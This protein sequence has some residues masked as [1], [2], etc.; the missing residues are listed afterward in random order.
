MAMHMLVY[1]FRSLLTLP[2]PSSTNNKNINRFGYSLFCF[3]SFCCS[4]FKTPQFAFSNLD[5]SL[6]IHVF[7]SKSYHNLHYFTTDIFDCR[8]SS[9]IH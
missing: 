5:E 4:C 8:P 7:F 2:P 6:I 1:V 3:S 9:Q